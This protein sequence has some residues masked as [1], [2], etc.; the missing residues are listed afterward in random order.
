[1]R[2]TLSLAFLAPEIVK[3][4]VEGTLPNGAGLSRL[5]DPA[6]D[7]GEQRSALRAE[8]SM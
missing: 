8:R 3:A 1:M 5:T 2:L 4:A 6:L 7:W